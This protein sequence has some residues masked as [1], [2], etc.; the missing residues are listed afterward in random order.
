M[1]TAGHCTFATG[2]DGE[3]TTDDGDGSGGNDIWVCFLAEPDYTGI[4]AAPFIPDDNAGRYA[5]Y[6]DVLNASSTWHRG[7]AYPHPDFDNDAFFLADAGVVIL[8][9]PVDPGDVI[10]RLPRCDYLDQFTGGQGAHPVRGRGIRPDPFP[11][12]GSTSAA[13]SA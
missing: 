11:P 9:E 5:H 1:L 3:S 2:L 13:T 10:R 7:T 4:G 8:D 6:P 12:A